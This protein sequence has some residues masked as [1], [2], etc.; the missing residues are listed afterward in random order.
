M[1]VASMRSAVLESMLPIVKVC[2]GEDNPRAVERNR[3]RV[4]LPVASARKRSCL[5]Q[6]QRRQYPAGKALKY[7]HNEICVSGSKV[8]ELR[9]STVKPC[10]SSGNGLFPRATRLLKSERLMA[11]SS[12]LVMLSRSSNTLA[13]KC[14][15]FQFTAYRGNVKSASL[16]G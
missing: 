15:G 16:T 9:V 3:V 13:S 11:F 5:T 2:T 6:V 4:P 10:G 7:V 12:T 1:S 14:E 8:M